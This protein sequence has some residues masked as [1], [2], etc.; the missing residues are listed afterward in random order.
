VTAALPVVHGVEL[1]A[2]VDRVH[3]RACEVAWTVHRGPMDGIGAAYQAVM[4]WMQHSGLAATGGARE[5]SLVLDADH[6]ERCITE[7]QIAVAS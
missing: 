3:L 4:S 2:P 7:L 5:I 1:P 6:P